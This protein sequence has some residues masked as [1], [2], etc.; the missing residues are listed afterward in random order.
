MTWVIGLPTVW[1][2]SI[3]ISDIC[4][5][6]ETRQKDCVQKIYAVAPGVA[7]AFAGSIAIGFEMVKHTRDFIQDVPFDRYNEIPAMLPEHARTVFDSFDEAYRRGGCEV[8]LLLT[9][10]TRNAGEA[11]WAETSVHIYRGPPFEEQP[12]QPLKASA[13]GSGAYVDVCVKEIEKITSDENIEGLL[14]SAMAGP[15]ATAS[16]LAFSFSRA[17]QEE[18]P[19][20][21]SPHMHFCVVE[22]GRVG[23]APNDY[24]TFTREGPVNFTMPKVAQSID[25]LNELFFDGEGQTEDALTSLVG[26]LRTSGN[27]EGAARFY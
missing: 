20:G 26:Y 14:R 21:I 17:L 13:I 8:M 27:G 10:P 1:G 15:G 18:L 24:R 11:P 2:V 5:S 22:R 3:G 23:I 19:S 16:M 25:V 9:D 6:T 12:V 7:L 4:A